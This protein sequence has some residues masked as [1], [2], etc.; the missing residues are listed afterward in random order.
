MSSISRLCIVKTS[1]PWL[2]KCKVCNVVYRKWIF[3]CDSCV[4]YVDPEMEKYVIKIPR[5]QGFEYAYK[6]MYSR[7]HL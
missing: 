1:M 3:G 2:G 7:Y 6:R 4:G 5:V